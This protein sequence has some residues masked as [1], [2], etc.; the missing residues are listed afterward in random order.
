MIELWGLENSFGEVVFLR[1]VWHTLTVA[2]PNQ[3]M[4]AAHDS[5]KIL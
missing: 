3:L 2:Y 1:K 4:G 5:D